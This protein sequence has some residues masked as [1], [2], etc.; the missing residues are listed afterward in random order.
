M[1]ALIPGMAAALLFSTAPLPADRV[2]VDVKIT[3]LPGADFVDPTDTGALSLEIDRP[4]RACGGAMPPREWRAEV[5]IPGAAA[6]D[7]LTRHGSMVATARLAHRL[8]RTVTLYLDGCVG[9]V[10]RVVGI[11]LL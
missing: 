1:H 11:E 9:N 10:A 4:H 8:G 3:A 7:A 5:A 2:A 6:P